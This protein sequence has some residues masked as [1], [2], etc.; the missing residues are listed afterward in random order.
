[1]LEST[2]VIA[3]GEMGRTPFLNDRGGRDHWT[4]CWPI[5]VAGGGV[6]GGQVIGASD[7]FGAE[8]KDRPLHAGQ[9]F[10]T[11]LHLLGAEPN[12]PTP[13]AERGLR[14]DHDPIAELVG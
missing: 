12:E 6:R 1:M 3:Q 7:A 4:R 11:I 14:T 9:I 13:A 2:L 10:A 5:L 8:P